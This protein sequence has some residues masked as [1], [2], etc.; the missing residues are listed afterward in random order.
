MARRVMTDQHDASAAPELRK[1]LSEQQ[2][3]SAL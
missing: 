3:Q 2:G 1:I